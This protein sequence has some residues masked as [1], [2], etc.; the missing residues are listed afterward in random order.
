MRPAPSSNVSLFPVMYGTTSHSAGVPH[1]EIENP[2]L[3]NRPATGR[4]HVPYVTC[5]V[6][7][8]SCWQIPFVLLGGAIGHPSA[9]KKSHSIQS[10][11][12][13]MKISAR[14]SF[15]LWGL[16]CSRWIAPLFDFSSVRL[17]LFSWHKNPNISIEIIA[18]PSAARMLAPWDMP[19][20]TDQ[21]D[22]RFHGNILLFRVSPFLPCSFDLW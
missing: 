19:F 11:Q 1:P 22:Q 9:N 17:R 8:R 16:N 13:S 12:H 10:T 3:I 2:S 6:G 18:S 21:G 4:P 5:S 20:P 15:Y 7:R 14:E